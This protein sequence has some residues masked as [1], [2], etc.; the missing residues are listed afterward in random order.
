MKA[1]IFNKF[2]MNLNKFLFNIVNPK[3]G[4]KLHLHTYKQYQTKTEYM[5]WHGR[6]E[7]VLIF[8]RCFL[9][10]ILTSFF[11]IPLRG[12][13]QGLSDSIIPSFRIIVGFH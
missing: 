6:Y 11:L 9:E 4:H 8:Y 3:I 7:F 1:I 12:I 2:A 10:I 5:S 13:G